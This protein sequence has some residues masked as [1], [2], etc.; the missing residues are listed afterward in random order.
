MAAS[1]GYYEI[2]KQD[3]Q[4]RWRFKSNNN[5]IIASG[6]SYFNKADCINAIN[7]MKGS[8]TAPVYER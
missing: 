3:Y 5:E 1:T 7:L 4:W 6:E 8:G 2:Y